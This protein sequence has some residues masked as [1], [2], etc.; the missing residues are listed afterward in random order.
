MS[1]Q[2]SLPST[3]PAPAKDCANDFCHLA[4][5]DLQSPLRHSIYMSECVQSYL[6]K[7]DYV[8]ALACT[9]ELTTTLANMKKLVA[10]LL[11]LSLT[12]NLL[13]ELQ[14]VD[15]HKIAEAAIAQNR[16]A[17]DETNATITIGHMPAALGNPDLLTRALRILIE[18]A[19]LYVKADTRPS[20]LIEGSA[21]HGITTIRIHDNGI[22]IPAGFRQRI[23]EP[24][25]RLHH[26]AR[27]QSGLGIGLSL[28][29]KIMR[30]H[31]GDV[32]AS[33]RP[34][35]GTKFTLTLPSPT[36]S[37]SPALK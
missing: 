35:G 37:A 11:D 26:Q 16:V 3:M 13:T 4:A 5:N 24:L 33:P 2:N 14:L 30:C 6:E 12:A 22:G 25:V 31:G 34:D 23:F 28:C 15:T 7:A 9:S 1:D 21:K 18:N 29:Q 17:I 8:R 32:A 27:H 36:P 20:V 10:A 19:I